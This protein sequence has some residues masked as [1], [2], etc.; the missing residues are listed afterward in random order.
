LGLDVGVPGV[1]P[2]MIGVDRAPVPETRLQTFIIDKSVNFYLIKI[3][4]KIGI[5]RKK[6]LPKKLR[7]LWM[8]GTNKLTKLSQYVLTLTEVFLK[9]EENK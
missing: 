5:K 4:I 2:G 1:P 9:S 3:Q 8:K 6:V 7:D